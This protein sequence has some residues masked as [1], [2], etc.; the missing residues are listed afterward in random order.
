[1]SR[2]EFLSSLWY[3][4]T[5]SD[6]WRILKEG[7]VF[8][9]IDIRVYIDVIYICPFPVFRVERSVIER[10]LEDVE[11][12]YLNERQKCTFK[13]LYS[14]MYVYRSA[15]CCRCINRFNPV[16]SPWVLNPHPSP[17]STDP[18][19]LIFTPYLSPI[20]KYNHIYAYRAS[21]CCRCIN[22]FHPVLNC[23]YGRK[24]E[25]LIKSFY[26]V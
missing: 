9:D 23:S 19:P 14:Y 4:P 11:E 22:R 5:L 8:K 16:L 12:R 2:K 21:S 20:Y 24:R 6:C 15:S 26:N 10:L 7:N 25:I 1:M 18:Y 3:A 13:L 17:L